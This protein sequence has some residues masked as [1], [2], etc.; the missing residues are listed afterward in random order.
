MIDIIGTLRRIMNKD[1]AETFDQATDS[2]EAIRSYLGTG[3]AGSPGIAY[4]GTVTNI[5]G[6][7]QFDISGF[8]GLYADTDF[9]NY[10]AWVRRDGA[11]GGVPPQGQFTRI[12]AYVDATGRFTHDA[13]NLTAAIDTDDIIILIHPSLV[14]DL[15]GSGMLHFDSDNGYAGTIYPVGS[16]SKP[17]NSEADILAVAALIDMRRI[18]VYGEFTVPAAMEG[19]EL[20]GQNIYSGGDTVILNGQDVDSSVFRRLTINGA[21]GGTGMITLEDCSLTAPTNIMGT[22]FRCLIQ[23]VTFGNGPIDAVDCA[24][25]QGAAAI[26]VDAPNPLNLYGWSGDINLAGQTGGV[27]NI[28]C[29]SGGTITLAASCTG[30]VINIYGNAVV[31]DNSAGSTVNIHLIVGVTL[32]PTSGTYSLPDGVAENTAL[33]ITPTVVAKV[34]TI[35][36]DMSNLTQNCTIRIKVRIDGANYQTIETFAWTTAMDD[37]AFFREISTAEPVQVSLQSVIAEG[38]NRDVPWHYVVEE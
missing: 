32:T 5:P 3:G 29:K 1:A 23:A 13:G 10:Y 35:F 24:G 25:W 18:R 20:T 12:T 7:N 37:G 26:T 9:E 38:A 11:V 33:T 4:I 14:G 34:N 17:S 8:I 22:L 15:Y 27:T 6:A 19:Y 30:G 28:Y 2:L 31:V 16:P 36:L 21:Q